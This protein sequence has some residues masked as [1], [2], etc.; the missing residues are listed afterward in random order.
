MP[1]QGAYRLSNVLVNYYT[2]YL[3]T[4]IHTTDFYDTLT[5]IYIQYNIPPDR[6]LMVEKVE[7]K[8]YISD[9]DEIGVFALR[10]P[11]RPDMEN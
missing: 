4:E 3:I 2:P 5:N 10:F 6:N 7:K 8:P 9:P 1:D 11:E